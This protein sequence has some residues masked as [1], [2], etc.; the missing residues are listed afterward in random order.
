VAQEG[1][2][3]EPLLQ[4]INQALL[5]E[6]EMRIFTPTIGD[7]YSL[8]VRPPHWWRDFSAAYPSRARNLFVTTDERVRVTG[9]DPS[10]RS[11]PTSWWRRLFGV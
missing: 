7:S 2:K 11:Q 6:Y 3:H 5:P 8:L 1:I 10:A 9:T 4:S